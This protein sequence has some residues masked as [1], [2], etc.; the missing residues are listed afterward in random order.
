MKKVFLALAAI[1]LAASVF[2][3][4]LPNISWEKVEGNGTKVVGT[5]DWGGVK[6]RTTRHSTDSG[7]VI[8]E[9]SP[10]IRFVHVHP[11]RLPLD[12]NTPALFLAKDARV[13]T[14]IWMML[15]SY[16]GSVMSPASKEQTAFRS[17][18]GAYDADCSRWSA[19]MVDGTFYEGYFAKGQAT[20]AV[21]PERERWEI[22]KP[23]SVLDTALSIVCGR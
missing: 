23:G 15:V 16:P 17:F 10:S 3:E 2:A 21:D 18:L 5:V 4:Q 22:V 14:R 13:K 6:V 8:Y 1:S 19:K 11:D 12:S 7:V 9:Y 20:Q